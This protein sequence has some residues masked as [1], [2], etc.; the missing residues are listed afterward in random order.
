MLKEYRVIYNH[1]VKFRTIITSFKTKV[2]EAYLVFFPTATNTSAI[3]SNEL[4]HGVLNDKNVSKSTELMKPS[5]AVEQIDLTTKQ[6]IHTFV[7]CI[8]AGER[9]HFF[10][11]YIIILTILIVPD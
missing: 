1:N 3:S 4:N 11:N 8:K 10:C 9:Y 6:V 2:L 5:V 7:N